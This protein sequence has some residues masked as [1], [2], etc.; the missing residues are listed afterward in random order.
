MCIHKQYFDNLYSFNIVACLNKKIEIFL[1]LDSSGSIDQHNFN[2]Q[3]NFAKSF[4]ENLDVGANKIRIGLM[5]HSRYP[6]IRF[7]LDEYTN[8]SSLQA[9]SDVDYL[10]FVK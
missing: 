10:V 3:K 9:I 5:T 7:R 6:Y 2:L 1:I 4:V 8:Q